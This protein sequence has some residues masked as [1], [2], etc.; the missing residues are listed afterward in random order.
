[1]IPNRDDY[2]SKIKIIKFANPNYFG[3]AREE[4][5][6]ENIWDIE[7]GHGFAK[8][9]LSNMLTRPSSQAHGIVWKVVVDGYD[10]Q[11]EF[12]MLPPLGVGR[13]KFEVYFNRRMNHDVAPM[14]AMGVRA[15]YTQTSIAEDGEWRSEVMDNGDVVDV[16][17]AW[18]TISAAVRSMALTASM[19]P[20]HK[21][22]NTLKYRLKTPASM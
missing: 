22:M 4:I 10:A 12:E 20:L 3:S 21:M 13:H 14:L 18:L 5:A 15:P 17:T 19:L 6:R 9:D 7:A 11:D 2:S 8:Y 1:M 16:Y